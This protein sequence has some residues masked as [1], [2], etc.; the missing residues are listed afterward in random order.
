MKF[1]EVDVG[2]FRIYAGAVEAANGSGYVAAV[3]VMKILGRIEREELYRSDRIDHACVWA[4]ASDALHSAID[5]GYA[6]LERHWSLEAKAAARSR[7][8]YRT[9]AV[10]LREAV[11][12]QFGV[13]A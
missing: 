13:V 5:A 9:R 6:A 3:V 8:A 1:E 10:P 2:N 4:A 11:P 7:R 12:L